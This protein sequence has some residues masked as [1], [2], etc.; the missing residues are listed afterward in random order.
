MGVSQDNLRLNIGAG[1]H[2]L[3][4]W[5]NIDVAASPRASRPPDII[6]DARSI[7]L[8]D[9]CAIEVMAIHLIEHF[10]RWE[11]PTVLAEWRRL[12]KPGGKI[13][14]ECPNVLKCCQNVVDGLVRGGKDPEQLG[15]WGLYGDPR[16]ENPLMVHKWGWT[17][18]TLSGELRRAG[19]DRIR[20]T[21]T[22]WHA[23]GRA[24]RDMR[25]E[26]IRAP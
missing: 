6:N 11:V 22:Q 7:D 8:P 26:A 1:R 14:L 10:Y 4:G 5:I 3:D 21:P 13:A 16:E 2:V 23:C 25:I 20:E 9:Q 19:F 18:D 12:L 15:M 17:P 24:H